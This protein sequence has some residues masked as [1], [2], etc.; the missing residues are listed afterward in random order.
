MH[1][2]GACKGMGGH[3]RGCYTVTGY[4]EEAIVGAVFPCHLTHNACRPA[5][6]TRN[7]LWQR[8]S[9]LFNAACAV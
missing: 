8:T 7:T 1:V 3:W 5:T 4:V 2:V 9:S 6:R